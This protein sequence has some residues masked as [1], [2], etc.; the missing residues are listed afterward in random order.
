MKCANALP[1]LCV[2]K[3]GERMGGGLGSETKRNNVKY[4]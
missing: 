4:T 1:L 2:A 3:A